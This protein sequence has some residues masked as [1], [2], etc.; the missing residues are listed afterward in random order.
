MNYIFKSQRSSHLEISLYLE[1]KDDMG[2]EFCTL[3]NPKD[4]CHLLLSIHMD[5]NLV[6]RKHTYLFRIYLFP[7]IMILEVIFL[8]REV[9]TSMSVNPPL[10]ISL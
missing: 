1:V 7:I 2:L 10:I 8:N 4:R 3:N 5:I 9:R 6:M